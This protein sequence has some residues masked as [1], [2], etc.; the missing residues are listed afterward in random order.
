LAIPEKLTREQ[1]AVWYVRTLGLETAVKNHSIY[2]LH[3]SDA[4]NIQKEFTGYIALADSLQL[5][6]AEDNRFKPKGEVTYAD[7]AVSIFDLA[8]A[9]HEHGGGDRLY[10]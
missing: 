2:K 10:Y 4:Y 7:I 1:L 8:H 5:L 9:I 6:S 3:F